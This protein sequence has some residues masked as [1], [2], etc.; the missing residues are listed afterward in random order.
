MTATATAPHAGGA[1]E[2]PVVGMTP[3]IDIVFQLLVF[4]LLTL[5]F[6]SVEHRIETRLPDPGMAPTIVRPEER[7]TIVA[8]LHRVDA[9]D[10]ERAFT[11]VR[12][13]TRLTVDLPAGAASGSVERD[14]DRTAERERATAGLARA[15]VGIHEDQGRPTGVRGEIRTPGRLP[16]AGSAVP[17]GDV[18]RVLDAF[19]Q[20]GVADV[21]FQ[22]SASPLPSTGG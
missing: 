6:K 21:V 7:P 2:D 20:A 13:G 18:M 11:R 9:E 19:L 4:F 17:H 10:P 15:I 5:R 8:T 14:A 3:M 1:S 12:L 22:G 16:G